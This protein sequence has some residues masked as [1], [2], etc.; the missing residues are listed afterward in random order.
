MIRQGRTWCDVSWEEAF[1]EV[2]RGL[3]PIMDAYGRNSVGVFLG[4]PNAHTMAGAIGIRPFLMALGSRNVFSASSV[5]QIPKHL[6]CGLMF[7]SPGT[8]PI[9]DIDRTDY[10]LMLGANPLESNGSLCTAPDFPGRLKALRAR[11]GKLVVVDPI[12]TRTAKRAD[13]HICIRP[14]TDP[15]LLF[16]IIDTLF[17]EGRVSLGSLEPYITGVTKVRDL[18]RA[19]RPEA[20]ARVCGIEGG[21]IRRLARELAAAPRAAVYGRMGVSTVEFGTLGNWLVDVVNVLTGNFDKAGGA[22]FPTP[23]HVSLRSSPGGKGFETGRWHSRVKGLPEVMGEFPVAT[24][25]DEIETPGD[26]RIRALVTIAGN[27]VLSTPNSARLDRAMASLDF[28]ISLDFYLNETTRHA[29]VILPP[30]SPLAHGQYDFFFYALSARNVV[31]YSP[32][33]T[34]RSEDEMDKWEILLR[35][36]LLVGGQGAKADPQALDDLIITQMIAREVKKNHSAVSGRDPGDIL[37]ALGRHRGPERILDF[38]LRNGP[39]GEGFGRDQEGLSLDVLKQNPHGM[40]LGPLNP[41]I[42]EIL[43]TPSEK[44]E[45]AP[46]PMLDDIP[47]LVASMDRTPG[48]ALLLVGRRH[49]RSNNSW[50]HNIASLVRGKDRCTLQIHPQDAR[51]SG[52]AHGDMARVSS[53]AGSIDVPA[54]ITG[55]MMPGVV[56][57]PH[58]WGHDLPG[59]AV[60]IASAHPGVNS[61]ILTDEEKMDPL[62]GNAVL[63]GIPVSVETVG[64]FHQEK[65]E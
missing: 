43:R 18:A 4:N 6:A 45:L 28:M 47:R 58:G 13:E 11:G 53:R 65:E 19:F 9:P 5:D 29:R 55:D 49:L 24:L 22:M 52:L 64:S 21:T 2:E 56:S 50:M 12:R 35:M 15:L 40:D 41:R 37:A 30:A 16:S 8:I 3:M 62:S 36:A 60:S 59:T 31:N 63:N 14:G 42:P 38:M 26:G 39:Y 1:S 20:V 57:I 10:L 32:P 34:D 48:D 23:A 33:V 7:G 54:E 51:R 25:A 44:I 46:K 61:N 17:E 27:P